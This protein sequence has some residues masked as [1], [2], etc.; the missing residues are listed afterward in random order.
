M[1]GKSINPTPI[2]NISSSI[3]VDYFCGRNRLVR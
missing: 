1:P 2:K 3:A